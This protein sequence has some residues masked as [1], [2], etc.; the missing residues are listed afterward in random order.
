MLTLR[1]T[2]AIETAAKTYPDPELR[3][4]L[5]S[6]IAGL[7]GY[8]CDLADLVHVLIVQ[9]GDTLEALEAELGFSPIGGD[10]EILSL[11][12]GWYEAVFILSDDGFGWV[13]FI[14]HQPGVLPELIDFC[15]ANVVGPP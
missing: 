3:V 14:P 7:Q 9:P 11:T 6:R 10:H 2:A 4:L 15:A 5:T 8:D 1:T 13:V 12:S